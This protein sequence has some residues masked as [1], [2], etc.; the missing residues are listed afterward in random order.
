MDP[1]PGEKVGGRWLRDEEIGANRPRPAAL[2]L[3]A[4]AS[5]ALRW[6]CWRL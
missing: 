5:G 3:A 2:E 4:P 6:S 1:F